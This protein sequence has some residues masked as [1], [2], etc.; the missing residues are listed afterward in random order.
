MATHDI[1]I[2]P[3]GKSKSSG[4]RIP[5]LPEEIEVD[6]GEL[7]AL[8]YNILDQGPVHIPNGSNLGS[9]RFSS[10]FPGKSRTKASL[11]FIRGSLIDPKTLTKQLDYWKEKGTKLKVIMTGTN[12]NYSVYVS[13]FTYKHAGGYGDVSYDLELE[14]RREVKITTIKQTSKPKN[15]AKS[16]TKSTTTTYTIKKGDTLWGIAS[17]ELG[18]GTRWKE[19][20]TLNKSVIES[21]A[22]KHGKKSSD[23]GHWIY[24][25]CKLK[26]PKK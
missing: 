4:I 13:N 14:T 5:W 22:K 17:K 2:Y 16:A 1:Y 7:R 12:I 24:P 19:I 18:K 8:E 10:I 9:I 26:L 23:G 11:P 21:T 6:M 15:K 3:E 20:Y 25:G